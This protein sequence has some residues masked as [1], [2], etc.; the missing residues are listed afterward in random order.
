MGRRAVARRAHRRAKG[1]LHAIISQILDL[2]TQRRQ[3]DTPELRTKEDRLRREMIRRWKPLAQQTAA[4]YR[5]AK[6]RRRSTR[7]ELEHLDRQAGRPTPKYLQEVEDPE[8]GEILPRHELETRQKAARQEAL[9]K[10]REQ[11]RK[12]KEERAKAW[13]TTKAGWAK[14]REERA[15]QQEKK[16]AE[17]EAARKLREA[18]KAKKGPVRNLAG[19]MQQYLEAN[20][21]SPEEQAK[22]LA[23]FETRRKAEDAERDRLKEEARQKE[24]TSATAGRQALDKMAARYNI[25]VNELQTRATM[26]GRTTMA[27]VGTGGRGTILKAWHDPAVL[28]RLGGMLEKDAARNAPAAAKDDKAAAI[29]ERLAE[30]D[31]HAWA[32][33]RG[34][35]PS[36]VKARAQQIA[37][38]E[39][40]K[41][42][43]H[44]TDI[45]G[46]AGFEI[47]AEEKARRGQRSEDRGRKSENNDRGDAWE[48]TSGFE[49]PLAPKED[50]SIPFRRPGPVERY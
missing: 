16:K 10:Q 27:T 25:P 33:Q 28:E 38:R 19:Q 48:D 14:R 30:E 37:E 21:E 12:W 42:P 41:Q 35:A 36:E 15:A 39:G 7:R 46:K 9:V 8:T 4:A 34:L 29:G 18:E 1:I 13:E 32:K 24:E 11:Q 20:K 22:R 31:A 43:W 23:E 3:E 49:E 47:D 17:R 44:H 2:L 6:G 50:D 45:L 5:E 26:L 40:N